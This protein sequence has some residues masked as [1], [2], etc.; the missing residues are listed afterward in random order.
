MVYAAGLGRVVLSLP[1]CGSAQKYTTFK[2]FQ[3]N[4]FSHNFLIVTLL[5]SPLV[6]SAKAGRSDHVGRL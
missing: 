4:C 5:I 1:M 6:K 3:G 2:F